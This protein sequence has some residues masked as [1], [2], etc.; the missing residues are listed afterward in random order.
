[1]I[2]AGGAGSAEHVGQVVG[3][4]HADAVCVA[5][6]LHYNT[7]RTLPLDVGEFAG[8]G[9][10]ESLRKGARFSKIEDLSLSD[11]KAWLVRRG[12]PCRPAPARA[13]GGP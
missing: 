13:G 6:L 11:L 3:E 12:I 1:V 8:E 7:V 9:N 5:S 10:I 2:A 4:G